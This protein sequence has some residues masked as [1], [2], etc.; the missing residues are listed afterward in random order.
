METWYHGPI[1][2]RLSFE[3]P[4]LWPHP[5][6]IPKTKRSGRRRKIELAGRDIVLQTGW[7]PFES[8]HELP[9]HSS[10]SI[11]ERHERRLSDIPRW[12]EYKVKD[13]GDM[14]AYI[15]ALRL[16]HIT[17][18]ACELDADRFSL[19]AIEQDCL[20]AATELYVLGPPDRVLSE[21]EAF[22]S[23][24]PWER[25][26]NKE[27]FLYIASGLSGEEICKLI[28]PGELTGQPNGDAIDWHKLREI[29][30]L[31]QSIN[32]MVAA[33]QSYPFKIDSLYYNRDEAK[34]FRDI[35]QEHWPKLVEYAHDNVPSI[36]TF[37]NNFQT[38]TIIRHAKRVFPL[39]LD[40]SIFTEDVEEQ[41][42]QPPVF[43]DVDE[44]A[45]QLEKVRG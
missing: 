8:R 31:Y 6:T 23:I 27:I 32:C 13:N 35:A 26:V 18:I 10:F 15:H 29:F 25:E 16:R 14:N 2:P 19:T 39:E 41:K 4:D 30:S 9:L 38:E 40:L 21:I 11:L 20:R 42:P 5:H 28:G 12:T 24:T 17:V 43:T 45:L 34:F 3:P 22:P 36:W 7:T 33:L 37:F 44:L 1:L